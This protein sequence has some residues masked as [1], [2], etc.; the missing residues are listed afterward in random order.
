MQI[1]RVR[2]SLVTIIG[3]NNELDWVKARLILRESRDRVNVSSP[4]SS[5]ASSS[6][7]PYRPPPQQIAPPP[8]YHYQHPQ[9]NTNYNLPPPRFDNQT[10]GGGSTSASQS[11]RFK[12]SPFYR[13]ERNLSNVIQLPRAV[14]GDRKN[15]FLTFTLSPEQRALLLKSRESRDNDQYAVCVYCT[16]EEFYS[17]FRPASAQPEAPIEFPQTCEL[18]I[19]NQLHNANTKGIRKQP[20]SAPPAVVSNAS[21][22][23]LNGLNKLEIIYINTERV[24]LHLPLSYIQVC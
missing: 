8:Q 6:N 10:V 15:V 14:Q 18:R 3:A 24:R 5:V 13:V 4:T 21:S 22:F 17:T 11:I 7:T 2:E 9:Y 12:P 1:G 19:N 16:T 20:G 23:N